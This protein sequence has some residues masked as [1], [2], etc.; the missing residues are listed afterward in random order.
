MDIVYGVLVLVGDLIEF[1]CFVFVLLLGFF[2][3]FLKNRFFI[4]VFEVVFGV[5]E[6]RNWLR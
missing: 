3:F 4:R 2:D 6:V 1:F 5:M